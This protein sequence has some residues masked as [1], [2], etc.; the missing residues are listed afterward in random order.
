M[1]VVR[2]GVLGGRGRPVRDGSADSST[3]RRAPRG[4]AGALRG[5]PGDRLRVRARPRGSAPALEAAH[6]VSAAL[7][8]PLRR[9]GPDTAR[10]RR[11]RGGG[12]DRAGRRRG[13]LPWL[14]PPTARPR[15][16]GPV[17]AGRSRRPDPERAKA[18][19]RSWP[20][21]LRH[22]L[23]RV[24]ASGAK[25]SRTPDLRYANLAQANSLPATT[26][27]SSGSPAKT[28]TCVYR[29]IP[30][31]TALIRTKCVPEKRTPDQV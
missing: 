17:G 30:G 16:G 7:T 19:R 10:W 24:N 14:V 3:S 11:C 8:V 4:S 21:G 6:P 15:F 28:R 27:E 31:P 9:P 13:A 26:R 5:P 20:G 12:H 22:V 1:H 2:V 18:T 25:G 29:D 23:N